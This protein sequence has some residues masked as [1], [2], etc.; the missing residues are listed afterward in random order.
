MST[1]PTEKEQ[2]L[3]LVKELKLPTFKDTVDAV[4]ETAVSEHWTYPGFLCEMMAREVAQRY[5]NRKYQR[6]RKAS[7]PQLLYLEP[8]TEQPCPSTPRKYFPN[9]KPW[10]L[11]VTNAISSCTE[12]REQARLIS[13]QVWVSRL[14]W[15]VF[16]CFSLLSHPS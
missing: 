13:L 4:T 8:W 9:S 1:K 2:L 3:S 12:I 11:S 15:R 14:A 16:P 5:E 10:I 7:F 6:I